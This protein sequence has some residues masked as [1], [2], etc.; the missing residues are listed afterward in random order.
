MA[1]KVSGIFLVLLQFLGGFGAW[2]FFSKTRNNIFLNSRMSSTGLVK[3]RKFIRIEKV[4]KFCF[5]KP[6]PLSIYGWTVVHNGS[7]GSV[8]LEPSAVRRL[9]L[10]VSPFSNF[11]GGGSGSC[12]KSKKIH[13]NLLIW[14][15]NIKVFLSREVQLI[16]YN[17]YG[18]SNMLKLFKILKLSKNVDLNSI[19]VYFC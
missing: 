4:L 13:N 2:T 11:G 3:F 5:K 14:L 16:N 12:Y 7:V 9:R 1:C 10:R 18:N 17:K 19:I 15:F 8:A 6:W